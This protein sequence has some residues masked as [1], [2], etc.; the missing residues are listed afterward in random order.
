MYDPVRYI[1]QVKTSSSMV[2]VFKTNVQG[3][4]LAKKI[5]IDLEQLLPNAKINFDLEDC[6]KILRIEYHHLI[7]EEVIEIVARKG[8][9]CEV[10]EY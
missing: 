4:R 9:S 5:I 2:E 3:T 10:L 8:F 6:D 7:V 1:S